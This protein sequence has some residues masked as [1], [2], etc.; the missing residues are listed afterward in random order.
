MIPILES[1]LGFNGE[2]ISLITALYILF[3]PVITAANV[4]GNGA[5]A[6][7]VSKAAE[8]FSS[9]VNPEFCE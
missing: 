2:M 7:G 3:D 5:F 1:H 6:M 8:S 4:M 9:T